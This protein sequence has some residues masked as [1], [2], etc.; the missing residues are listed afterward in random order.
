MSHSALGQQVFDVE[1]LAAD[2]QRL[3][4]AQTGLRQIA[5]PLVG[6]AHAGFRARLQDRLDAVIGLAQ[7]PAIQLAAAEQIIE[8]GNQFALAID[9]KIL[10]E[11][12]QPVH[13][14]P[15]GVLV[16]VEMAIGPAKSHGMIDPPAQL[17]VAGQAGGRR[18]RGSVLLGRNGRR[19]GGPIATGG[20]HRQREDQREGKKQ[21]AIR[22][23]GEP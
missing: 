14:L 3:F 20:Q 6:M 19:R 8:S 18:R 10:A 1:L 11:G 2:D 12:Q 13:D 21:L 7:L 22:H 15:G 23:G 9:F 17:F 4:Q 16:A 5:Q